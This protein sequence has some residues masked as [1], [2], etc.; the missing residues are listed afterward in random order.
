MNKYDSILITRRITDDFLR[1][2]GLKRIWTPKLLWALGVGT[3]LSGSFAKVGLGMENFGPLALMTVVVIYSFVYIVF[4]FIVSELAVY[5]YARRGLGRFG[6]YLAGTAAVVEFNC[7][8][9]AVLVLFKDF[10]DPSLPISLE[11]TVAVLVLLMLMFGHFLSLR[12]A[13]SVQ[14]FLTCVVVSGVILFFMGSFEAVQTK[15]LI[16]SNGG[17]S[18]WRGVFET[19]PYYLMLSGYFSVLNR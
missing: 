1:S 10:I 12:V 13:A 15:Q 6:G 4:A 5:S 8:A 19:L 17:F 9:A 2:Q 7:A 3:A 16:D 11:Y 18:D 14:F